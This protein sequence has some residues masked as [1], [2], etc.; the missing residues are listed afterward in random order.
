[1]DYKYIPILK[2]KQGEFEALEKTKNSV[3]NKVL[4]LFEVAK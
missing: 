1:M 4:P 3:S 2:A